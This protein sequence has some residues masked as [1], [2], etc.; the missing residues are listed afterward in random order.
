MTSYG[1]SWFTLLLLCASA[2]LDLCCDRFYHGSRQAK[3]EPVDL[4][5]DDYDIS[6]CQQI[7]MGLYSTAFIL[8]SFQGTL[9]S[10]LMWAPFFCFVLF[11]FVLFFFVI[12]GFFIPVNSLKVFGH[13]IHSERRIIYL[14]KSIQ[15]LQNDTITISWLF[16]FRV[17]QPTVQWHTFLFYGFFFFVFVF[18]FVFINFCSSQKLSKAFGNQRTYSYRTHMTFSNKIPTKTFT[19]L[20]MSFYAWYV[21]LMCQTKQSNKRFPLRELI[22]ISVHLVLIYILAFSNVLLVLALNFMVHKS[23]YCKCSLAL[24]QARP[25]LLFTIWTHPLQMREYPLRYAGTD[26]S[27]KNFKKI[28]NST[29]I[30]WTICEPVDNWSA[31]VVRI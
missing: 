7:L 23:S 9:Q 1:S 16:S 31:W 27:K 14:G 24:C 22:Y 26:R 28:K 25:F 30:G 29:I 13:S 4:V 11:Y 12:V 17:I 21:T 2:P 18:M 20:D 19:W 10:H 5:T 15:A 8:I 6:L 3:R